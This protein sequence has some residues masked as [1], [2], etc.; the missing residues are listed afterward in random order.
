MSVTLSWNIA[1]TA[2]EISKDHKVTFKRYPQF[3]SSAEV[4]LGLIGVDQSI[5]TFPIILESFA[6]RIF[7]PETTPITEP[8]IIIR[9]VTEQDEAFYRMEVNVAGTEVANHTIFLA[10]FGNYVH[11]A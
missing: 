2:Q 3:N 11:L 8:A 10:V 6:P 5:G 1:F 7:I 9:N 4:Q